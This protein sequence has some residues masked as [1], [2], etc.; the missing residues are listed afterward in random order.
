MGTGAN[1]WERTLKS[2]ESSPWTVPAWVVSPA[3]AACTHFHL[4]YRVE[5]AAWK[6]TASTIAVIW[7]LCHDHA[8]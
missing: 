6:P 3:K 7:T 4:T 2:R 8:C 5:G 1:G